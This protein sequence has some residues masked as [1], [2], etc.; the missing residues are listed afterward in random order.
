MPPNPAALL[1]RRLL[2]SDSFAKATA[3]P[4]APIPTLPLRGQML[5]PLPTGGPYNAD[6]DDDEFSLNGL[7]SMLVASEAADIAARSLFSDAYTC[8][9]T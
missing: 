3:R 7:Q 2:V 8:K 4:Q 1:P 5:I 9:N 6:F